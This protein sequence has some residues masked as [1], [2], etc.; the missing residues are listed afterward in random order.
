MDINL[1]PD[2]SITSISFGYDI[3]LALLVIA[4]PV[5]LIWWR[6]LKKRAKPNKPKKMHIAVATII[7]AIV[8]YTII[9]IVVL[10]IGYYYFIE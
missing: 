5:C 8:I 3:L 9:V 10:L 6:I 1:A 2:G 7:T 4:I